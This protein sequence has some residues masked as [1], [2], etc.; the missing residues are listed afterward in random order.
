LNRS[1]DKPAK[2]D[3]TGAGHL[4]WLVAAPVTQEDVQLLQTIR[5][6]ATILLKGDFGLLAGVN[7]IK[8]ERARF[9]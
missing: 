8:L 1:N 4:G 9:G 2:P 3:R 6:E 5:Q 7:V